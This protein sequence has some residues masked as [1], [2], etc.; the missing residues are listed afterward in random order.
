M[1]AAMRSAGLRDSERVDRSSILNRFVKSAACVLA[2]SA[3]FSAP[4]SA[5]SNPLPTPLPSAPTAAL[6]SLRSA[7]ESAWLR[8]TSSREADADRRQGEADKA[9]SIRP[10]AA[11]PALELSHR[12]DRWQSNAGRRETEVGVA[13]PLWLPGQRAAQGAVADA[14]ASRAEAAARVARLKIAGQVREAA[15]QLI[16]EQAEASELEEQATLLARLHQDVERRVQAG[17]LARTDALAARAEWLAARAR[18][19]AVA[20][21]LE[22]ARIRWQDLTG[23]PAVLDQVTTAE[24]QDSPQSAPTHPELDLALHDVEHARQLLQLVRRSQRDAPEL[25]VGLR[26]DVSGGVEGTHNSLTVGIRVPF[27]TRDRNQPLEVSASTRLDIA[28]SSEQRLRQRIQADIA[29]ARA[30]VQATAQQLAME[31][32]RSSLLRERATLIDRSFRAGETALA[33]FL[34]ALDAAARAASAVVRQEVALELARSRVQQAS[35][36]LP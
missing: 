5:Q 9:A 33:D 24:P 22:L 19:A 17:D 16:A 26:Q 10:W 31:L 18:L 32:E 21:R 30:E 20:Q 7:V 13:W 11:P 3:V 6:A 2:S 14:A 15:W 23:L 1:P 4:C 36:I 28:S 25:K 27:G 12:D 8:A 35:G 29:A 34:R